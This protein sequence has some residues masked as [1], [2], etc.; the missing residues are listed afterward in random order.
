MIPVE[1]FRTAFPRATAV[2]EPHLDML[3]KALSY[4]LIGVINVSIDTTVF[5][6]LYLTDPHTISRIGTFKEL[7]R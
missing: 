6:I 5:P 1:R 7:S 3:R 2:V 4:A